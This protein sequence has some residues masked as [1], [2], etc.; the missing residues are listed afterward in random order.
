MLLAT[1]PVSIIALALTT[2]RLDP[3]VQMQ[4]TYLESAS[5]L[6]TASITAI[7]LVKVF[8]GLDTELQRYSHATKLAAKHYLIQAQ[9]N[10][11]QTGYMAFYVI[12][13]FVVGFWYGLV[14]VKNGLSPGHVLT[15]FYATLAAFQSIAALMPHW[16][17]FSKGMFAGNFLSRVRR[18]DPAEAETTRRGCQGTIRLEHLVGDINLKNVCVQAQTCCYQTLADPL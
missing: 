6:T 5:K 17:V 4:K 15:T 3:A 18:S 14:L 1:L 10:S 13:M 9:C 12:F 11:I 2:Q 7:D 8:N 16:L